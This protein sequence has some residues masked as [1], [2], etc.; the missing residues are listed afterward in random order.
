MSWHYGVAPVS[1]LFVGFYV[2]SRIRCSHCSIEPALH[3][4][5][6]KEHATPISVSW[7][8]C[9]PLN[10]GKGNHSCGWI[11]N[12]ATTCSA[13][14]L[15]WHAGTHG[16]VGELINSTEAM[17][18]RVP[19]PRAMPLQCNPYANVDSAQISCACL[20][21]LHQRFLCQHQRVIKLAAVLST[22]LR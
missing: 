8:V 4:P 21:D 5:G 13:A 14:I 22:S 18:E 3:S 1:Y 9:E 19:K 6:K 15:N 10:A 11:V 12:M 2:L 16:R 17:P 7:D 20:Q